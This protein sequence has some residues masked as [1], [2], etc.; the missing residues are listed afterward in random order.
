M[1][2]SADIFSGPLGKGPRDLELTQ[3]EVE[4]HILCSHSLK[5]Q[6]H[7]EFWSENSTKQRTWKTKQ[8]ERIIFAENYWLSTASL[9]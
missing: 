7:A 3:I 1:N 5:G 6:K 9:V 8:T 2:C 4:M